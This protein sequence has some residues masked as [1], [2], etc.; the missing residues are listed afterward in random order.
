MRPKRAARSPGLKSLQRELGT[1]LFDSVERGREE[2]L[3]FFQAKPLRHLDAGAQTD[4][5]NPLV[6]EQSKQKKW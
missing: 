6:F 1:T 2:D 5:A 3:D 4:A